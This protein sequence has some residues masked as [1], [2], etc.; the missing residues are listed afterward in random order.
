MKRALCFLL[1]LTPPAA[2]QSV[3]ISGSTHMRYIE[4]RPLVADS[5]VSTA[6]QGDG[7]LRQL[8]DGRILRCLPGDEFCYDVR[9]GVRVSSLPVIHDV[10]ASAWGFGAGVSGL[11][12]VRVRNA[13]GERELWPQGDEVFDVLAAYGEFARERG[14]VRIGRQWKA[15]GLGFYNFDGV[16]VEARPISTASIEAYVGRSLVRGLN[17]PRASGALESIE[18]LAPSATGLLIG[19]HA[20][21]F[22]TRSLALSTMYQVDLR[23]EGADFYSELFAAD[24]SW[25]T[26]TLMVEAALEV[27][28]ASADVN[29]ARLRI[30]PPILGRVAS[31]AEVRRYRPYFE[32]WTIWGA[33]SP[34]GFDEARVGLTWAYPAGELVLQGDA[35]YRSYGGSE[36][37]GSFGDFRSDGWSV[38]INASWSPGL[39]WRGDAGYRVDT[40]VGAARRE[41]HVALQ[42]SLGEKAS[43]AL[44]ALAFQTLY[45][46]RLDEG[47]VIGLGGEGSHQFSTRVGATIN[48]TIYKHLASGVAPTSDWNQRR[49]SM[50]VHWTVGSEPGMPKVA[51]R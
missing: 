40:S 20:R 37:D 14:R 26:R 42:K 18:A 38:A 47:T 29:E 13:F 43:I 41:G 30:R 22:P 28:A 21:Y 51:S 5:V 3:R 31:F 1:L 46:F 36:A 6:V 49:A 19:L 32:L 24:L 9:P 2:A 10:E 7:L 35:A 23:G 8:P 39:A 44:H 12:Q 48:A 33:F 25:Q 50:R 15:S 34:V 17:E 45:E 11:M 4:L 27:D 16:S